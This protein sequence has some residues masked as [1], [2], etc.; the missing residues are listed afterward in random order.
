MCSES[1]P[2]LASNKQPFLI[3]E[4][5][6]H[7]IPKSHILKKKARFKV[8]PWWKAMR[9]I[10]EP[11]VS[12]VPACER[13][14]GRGC[15]TGRW[16]GRWRRTSGGRSWTAAL[17]KPPSRWSDT[18]AA[19]SCAS[20]TRMIRNTFPETQR[21]NVLLLSVVCKAVLKT[22]KWHT[23]HDLSEDEH[24]DVGGLAAR[25]GVEELKTKGALNL[26]SVAVSG[27]IKRW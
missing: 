5:A 27:C 18:P 14:T 20:A 25:Y 9:G 7:I 15:S 1:S 12:L 21:G 26:W 13:D 6:V 19:C 23:H 3:Q 10:R 22:I 24:D 4:Q 11:C 8:T 17:P 16:P 2:S